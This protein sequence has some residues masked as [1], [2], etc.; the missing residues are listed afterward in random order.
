[1]RQEPYAAM[2]VLLALAACGGPD[3]KDDGAANSQATA[4]AATDAGRA[5]AAARARLTPGR[6]EMTVETAAIGGT[7]MPP[8]LAKMMKGM[9]VTNAT[10]LTPEQAGRPP[11]DMF[12][13][14][15]QGNCAYR[16]FTLAG[17]KLHSAVECSG[18][19]AGKGQVRVTT[20]GQFGGEALDVRSRMEMTDQGRAMTMESHLVGRRTGECTGKEA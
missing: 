14:K 16:E 3:R 6:W 10:C 20:D 17:G 2:A 9:K 18:K 12:G 15:G 11:A 5:A 19:G 8:E 7:G 1:M 13:G 4:G